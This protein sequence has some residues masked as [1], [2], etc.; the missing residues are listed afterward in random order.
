MTL[1]EKNDLDQSVIYPGI[2]DE[3]KYKETVEKVTKELASKTEKRVVFVINPA[4]RFRVSPWERVLFSE[5]I[6]GKKVGTDY[7]EYK[8]DWIDFQGGR[9][10]SGDAKKI[11]FL[12]M[13]KN[14]IRIENL[15]KS[16]LQKSED[17]IAALE[18]KLAEQNSKLAELQAAIK[19]GRIET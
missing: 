13:H 15:P 12:D 16:P 4:N 14:F 7:P 10:V 9:W 1:V 19:S 11:A 18:E 5:T 17:K 2:Q 6:I 8:L 3:K